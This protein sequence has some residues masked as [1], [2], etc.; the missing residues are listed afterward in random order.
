MIEQ[1]SANTVDR[2][3]QPVGRHLKLGMVGGGGADAPAYLSPTVEDGAHG[4][5]FVEA[6]L[7]S[8]AKGG[9]WIDAT[10]AL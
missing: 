5:K 9:V 2:R 1:A 10:L 8:H 6:A 3:H 4:M 7:E